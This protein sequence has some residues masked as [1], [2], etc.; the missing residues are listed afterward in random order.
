[1]RLTDLRV[2]SLPPPESGQKTYRCDT[3][4]GF[5]VRVSQGGAKTFVLMVGRDRQLVSIG[6]YPIISLQDARTVA[7]EMLAER[8]LGKHRPARLRMADALTRYYAEKEAKNKAS[9]LAITRGIINRQFKA[10]AN[11]NL[12]EITPDDIAKATDKL[13]KNGHPSAAN[14]ALTAARTFFKWCTR[15]GYIQHS[16]VE[17]L[18]R[19]SRL[20]SRDRVLTDDELRTVWNA[21]DQVGYPFGDIVKLLIL[22]GQ[23]RTEIGSLKAAWCSLTSSKDGELSP[24]PLADG[25]V[26]TQPSICLPSEITKNHR[27]HTFPIGALTAT[28]L[29]SSIT[30]S[31]TL[32]FPARGQTTKPFNGWSKSKAGLGK[33]VS[34][35]IRKDAQIDLLRPWTLHDLR[36]TYATNLQRLGIKL[37]VI[38]ALLN[39]VSGT[40]AGIV[41]VYQRHHY[42][43]EMRAAVLLWEKHLAALIEPAT[44]PAPGNSG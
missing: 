38:E 39:H 36:R 31:T 22:T 32:L 12:D 17:N 42:M 43:D 8:T 20:V 21:A 14:H 6:R 2:Q 7:R 3:L 1:M 25:G 10:L 19:P 44:V 18:E 5:G 27:A 28:I 34:E 13:L 9:T 23:R 29:S 40:R 4:P 33:K 41:G 35:L 16:P 37:E 26:D 30:T 15:R 24:A 11:K